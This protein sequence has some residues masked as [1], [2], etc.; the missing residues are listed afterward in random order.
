M[1][2]AQQ[3]WDD[4]AKPIGSL[5]KI[6]GAIKKIAGIAGSHTPD[7]G[8][9]CVVVMCADNGIV[10]QGVTQSDSMV[11][12]IVTDNFT[13][14]Q[15]TVCVMAKTIGADIIPVD[16]GI[17]R[18][19]NNPDL[20][21][22]KLMYGTNDISL[23]SA[24]TREDAIKAIE[25]G[26]EMVGDLKEKGYGMIATGEMG[27]GNTTTSSAI[28]SVLLDRAVEEV[29]GRGAGL[30][31]EGLQRKADV[32]RRAIKVNQPDREDAIDVLSKIGGLDI[33]G[34][35]GLY[36]GGAVHRVPIVVDGFISAVAA[37]VAAEI[38][39]VCKDYM[40]PSHVSAEPAGRHVLDALGLSPLLT[41]DMC[42]GEGTG[43]VA[44]MSI[45]NMG[46]A[47][48]RDMTTFADIDIEAYVH[49]K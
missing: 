20:I 17:A 22:R 29:T 30:C 41:C 7:L 45:I 16:I 3:R 36:I 1:A 4:I 6:E 33:A 13:K 34:M 5:G 43:A 19:M 37:L 11:T 49:F 40:I 21:N 27:I 26:I 14:G 44:G 48:Y 23:G 12:A 42:L 24:M 47:V 35:A 31:D 10:G 15:A 46:L 28:V 39:P 32:I 25:V 8:K 38:A 2:S 9:Q 18:D